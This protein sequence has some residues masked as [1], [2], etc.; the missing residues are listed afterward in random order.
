MQVK[1]QKF[2]WP[3][4][5]FGVAVGVWLFWVLALVLMLLEGRDA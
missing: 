4:F 5:L 1:K 3:E 2:A